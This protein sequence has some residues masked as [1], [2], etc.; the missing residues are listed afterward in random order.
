MTDRRRASGHVMLICPQRVFYAGL[1]GRPRQ[2]T[3]GAFVVY[4]AIEGALTITR[5]GRTE[6]G[7]AMAMV[8]PYAVH[9]LSSDHPSI[10]CLMVEPETASPAALA[11]LAR[12]LAAAPDVAVARVRRA[13]GALVGRSGRDGLEAAAFDR[14]MF[15]ETLAPRTMDMRIAR[16]IGRVGAFDG[17]P[18]AAA[19]LAAEAGLSLSRFLHLFKEETGVSFRALR[20]WKRARNLLHFVDADINF[21]HLAQDIGYP[22]STHFS[23]SIRRYYGLKPRTI[24]DGSRDLQIYRDATAPLWLGG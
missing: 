1:L 14:L 20:A 10:I 18:P 9:S 17:A 5:D 15:G 11:G 3:S 23:H 16:A 13:Y 24:F 7:L 21:A 12:R 4:V 8:P 2:R 6:R 22:D 19:V